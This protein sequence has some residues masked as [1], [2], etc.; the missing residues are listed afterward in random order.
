MKSRFWCWD[1]SVSHQMWRRVWTSLWKSSVRVLSK[2]L[3]C[4]LFLMTQ[5]NGSSLGFW[6]WP[7]VLMNRVVVKLLIS[8]WDA[9]LQIF[10]SLSVLKETS[11]I[12]YRSLLKYM[13]RERSGPALNMS[14]RFKLDEDV[15]YRV[16]P[17]SLWALQIDVV[18]DL[19][20]FFESRRWTWLEF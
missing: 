20:W 9:S 3:R 6:R 13:I 12:L 14:H 16:G 11:D 8:W 17:L 10:S 15:L 2:F 4:F 5:Q 1:W 7:S 19:L 18:W